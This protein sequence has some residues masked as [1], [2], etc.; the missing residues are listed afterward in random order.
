MDCGRH[1]TDGRRPREA[2]SD[3]I[4]VGPEESN[5][6]QIADRQ[7]VSSIQIDTGRRKASAGPKVVMIPQHWRY[8]RAT[9]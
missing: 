2:N 5:E 9:D 4:Y 3:A 7:V 1:D 6:R 8:D